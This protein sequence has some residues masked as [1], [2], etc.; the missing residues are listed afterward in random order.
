MKD[1][2][3]HTRM[4]T[5]AVK[6]EKRK[7]SSDFKGN[8]RKITIYAIYIAFYKCRKRDLELVI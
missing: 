8:K 5:R 7:L 6:Y 2:H 1:T 3:M 4:R